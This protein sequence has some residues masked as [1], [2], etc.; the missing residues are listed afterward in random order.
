M[1]YKKDTKELARRMYAVEGKS[2]ADISTAMGIPVF[3]LYKWKT[4]YEWDKDIANGGNVSLYMNMQRQFTA[5]IQKAIDEGKLADP[6]TADS[7]WK[8]AKLMDRLMPEK[9]LL[10]NIFSFLEDL[11]GFF[12][13]NVG[14]PEFM[15][16]YQQLLPKLAD[17]LRG[18]YTNER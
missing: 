9:V 11:T 8:T 10:S 18:K 15:E 14:A 2:V 13:A 1:A 5:A 12:V 6:S 17:F 7:L 4:T 16:I 3:T